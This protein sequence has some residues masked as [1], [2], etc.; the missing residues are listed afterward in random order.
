[1]FTTPALSAFER[2][3]FKLL[4]KIFEGVSLL[5]YLTEDKG[6]YGLFK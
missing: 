2:F 6:K 3:R 1:L 5:E 4:E